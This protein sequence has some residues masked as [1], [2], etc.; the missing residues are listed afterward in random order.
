MKC[1]E[2]V[3]LLLNGAGNLVTKDMEQGEAAN[4]FFTLVGIVNT[5]LQES[6]A[7]ES[8][9]KVWSKTFRQ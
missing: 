4:A 7:P 6:Q 9:D 1:R 3:G 5:D 2:N 8:R